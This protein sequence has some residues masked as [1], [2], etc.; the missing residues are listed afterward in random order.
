LKN[1]DF[2]LAIF[3]YIGPSIAAHYSSSWPLRA[4]F[5]VQLLQL[6]KRFSKPDK[7]GLVIYP[8]DWTAHNFA[9]D[10]ENRVYLV[11]LEE[12]ISPHFFKYLLKKHFI[13]FLGKI[14]DFYG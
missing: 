6:A 3:E 11:D 7:T 14:N 5:A 2:R 4:Y 13:P 1:S 12:I 10:E 8:T 9:V